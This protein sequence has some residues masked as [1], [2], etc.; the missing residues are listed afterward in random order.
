MNR[1]INIHCAPKLTACDRWWVASAW[2]GECARRSHRHLF[3]KNQPIWQGAE[4][5]S[6]FYSQLTTYTAIWLIFYN[7]SRHSLMF[8]H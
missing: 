8:G 1:L 3:I 6:L 5:V 7:S 2:Y 4:E